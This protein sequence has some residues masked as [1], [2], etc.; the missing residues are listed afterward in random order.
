MTS[1]LRF[2]AALS[3]CVPRLQDKAGLPLRQSGQNAGNR[4]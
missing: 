2:N 1:S 3:A 4:Y